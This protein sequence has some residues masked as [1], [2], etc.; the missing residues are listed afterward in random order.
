MDRR[1]WRKR[2]QGT[3]A[4][5][6]DQWKIRDLMYLDVMSDTSSV[7]DPD[8]SQLGLSTKVTFLAKT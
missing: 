1:M 5:S 3:L 4:K 2:H 7:L 6:N 8:S